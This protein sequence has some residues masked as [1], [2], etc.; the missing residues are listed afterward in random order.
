MTVLMGKG[1]A[2]GS[3]PRVGQGMVADWAGARR[4]GGPRG[5]AQGFIG[6]KGSGPQPLGAASD[7]GPKTSGP[8]AR[9]SPAAD[10]GSGGWAVGPTTPRSWLRMRR[11]VA[12]SSWW[13]ESSTPGTF[14]PR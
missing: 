11:Q 9:R 14:Q 2:R 7:I 8:A 10:S 13:P 1:K 4:E 5:T 12:I 3:D 6:P